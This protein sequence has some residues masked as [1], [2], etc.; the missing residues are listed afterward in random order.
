MTS[1]GELTAGIAHEIQNPL[2]F[3]NNF[4]EVSSELIDELADESQ[5]PLRDANLQTELVTDLKDNLQ[6]IT[7]HGQR[8]SSI[9]KGMLQ[10]SR[11]ST[12][13]VQPTDLNALC[14][15]FLRLAFQGQR[16]K[17]KDFRCELMT[18]F[19][20]ALCLIEVMPQEMGQVLVN[21]FN[22]AF[23]AVHKRSQQLE[24]G[25]KGGYPTDPT[26]GS[27]PG[28]RQRNGD[29]SASAGE[30]LPALL[31][32]QAPGEGTGLGLSLAYDIITK[33][34]RGSLTVTSEEG[35]GTEL[36]IYLPAP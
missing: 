6:K 18:H 36:V 24:E 2:N 34:H 4:S 14:D 10:H 17:D 12:G 25:P 1:L 35:Q 29:E 13:E 32:H 15:E 22:N 19:D 11:T 21:L 33:G 16:A 26:R 23:Y 8:A 27:N 30:D 9:V 5:K 31:Y 20:P 28:S 3:V 7:H